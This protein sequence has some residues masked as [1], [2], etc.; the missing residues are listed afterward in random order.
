MGQCAREAAVNC[1]CASD[2]DMHMLRTNT[3]IDTCIAAHAE[4]KL[5]W[6]MMLFVT[7]HLN[8]NTHTLIL[9]IPAYKCIFRAE[10]VH[11]LNNNYDN[12]EII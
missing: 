8:K 6:T 1:K 3:H 2:A 10:K 12:Q 9:Q 5:S 4:A 11:S 7:T